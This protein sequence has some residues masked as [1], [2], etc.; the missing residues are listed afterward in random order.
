MKS[1]LSRYS[2]V[3]LADQ[4]GASPETS[5]PVTMRRSFDEYHHHVQARRERRSPRGA[6][7]RRR[8]RP[9]TPL[10]PRKVDGEVGGLSRAQAGHHRA[11]AGQ[12]G[13][14]GPAHPDRRLHR[15]AGPQG[16]PVHRCR[17]DRQPAAEAAGPALPGGRPHRRAAG[18]RRRPRPPRS[19]AGSVLPREPHRGRRSQQRPAGQPRV[20]QG[21]DRH[22]GVE[23]GAR[24]HAAGQGPGFGPPHSRDGGR[25]GLRL[26]ARTSP[27]RQ[28]RWSSAPRCWS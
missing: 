4:P 22:R 27:R 15:G 25:E 2:S 5:P 1:S 3:K 26:W 8:P 28:G 18:D 20:R 9:P 21:G 6:S 23:P 10:R 16:P 17:L 13:R 12:A 19:R 11:A 14:R 7:G 24:G